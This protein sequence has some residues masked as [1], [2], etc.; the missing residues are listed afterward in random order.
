[1]ALVCKQPGSESHRESNYT[2]LNIDCVR[3]KI[4]KIIHFGVSY[5]NYLIDKYFMKILSQIKGMGPLGRCTI[6][7]KPDILQGQ[8]NKTGLV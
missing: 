5:R 4:S 8:H 3:A 7:Q 6:M 2:G 1:M